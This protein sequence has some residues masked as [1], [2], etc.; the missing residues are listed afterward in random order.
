MTFTKVW[1]EGAEDRTKGAVREIKTNQQDRRNDLEVCRAW[2]SIV[3]VFLNWVIFPG[4]EPRI[5]IINLTKL[6]FPSGFFQRLFT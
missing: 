1:R 6:V 2:I 3:F 4:W 5:I